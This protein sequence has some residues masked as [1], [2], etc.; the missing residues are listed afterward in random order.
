MVYLLKMVYIYI[1]INIDIWLVTINSTFYIWYLTSQKKSPG[2]GTQRSQLQRLGADLVPLRRASMGRWEDP[3]LSLGHSREK[4]WKNDGK[5]WK[6]MGKCWKMMEKCWKIMGKCWKMMEK[7]WKNMERCWKMMGKW[8]KHDGQMMETRWKSGGYIPSW[9][10]WAN[11]RTSH[12][13]FV[14]LY[15]MWYE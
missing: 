12:A 13:T 8:W 7:C 2:P 10:T 3:V 14:T 9:C 11:L 15:L 6:I 1:H 5:C 4:S